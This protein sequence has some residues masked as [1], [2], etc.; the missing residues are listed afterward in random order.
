[1][2]GLGALH[3]QAHA[4]VEGERAGGRERRVLAEAVARAHRR[5]DAEPLDRV[6]HHEAQHERGQLRVAGV[7]QL[8]GVGVEQEALDIT[9]GDLAGLAHQL[10]GV[11]LR[12]GAPHAGALRALAREQKS[13]HLRTSLRRGLAVP[14]AAGTRRLRTGVGRDADRTRRWP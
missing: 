1:V 11:V 10:P 6:E 9:P 12:P 5:L 14:T 4:L 13:E 3:H 2:H 7:L 8:V